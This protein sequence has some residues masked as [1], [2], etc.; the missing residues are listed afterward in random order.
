MWACSDLALES[1]VL[2]FKLRRKHLQGITTLALGLHIFGGWLDGNPI[3]IL[4]NGRVRGKGAQRASLISN[5]L[6]DVESLQAAI[7]AI[8]N[9]KH[10]QKSLE[11][12]YLVLDV[13]PLTQLLVRL[14]IVTFVVV[15]NV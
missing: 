7:E 4:S 2:H 6:Q 9:D 1:I 8:T 15:T 3:R 14:T 12:L 5:D 11:Q 13:S 10:T